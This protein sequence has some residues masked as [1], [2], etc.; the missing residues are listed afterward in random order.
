MRCTLHTTTHLISTPLLNTHQ[1]DC[2]DTLLSLCQK[3]ATVIEFYLRL[4]FV[5]DQDI[6]EFTHGATEVCVSVYVCVRV[7]EDV[8]MCVCAINK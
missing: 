2:F 3:S 1:P 6:V 8:C 5:I 7:S 4:L